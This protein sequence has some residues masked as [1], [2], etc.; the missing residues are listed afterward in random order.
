MA[1]SNKGYVK[2][3]FIDNSG[4]GAPRLSESLNQNFSLKMGQIINIHY[5][6]ENKDAP[7]DVITYDVMLT[8]KTAN[9]IAQ[10]P[11]INCVISNMFGG[12]SDYVEYSLRPN[13]KS[14]IGIGA[15]DNA[16]DLLGSVV[17]V[18]YVDGANETPLIVGGV[19]NKGKGSK[20]SKKDD[21]H[22]LDFV[23]NGVN[24]NINKNGELLIRKDGPTKANGLLDEDNKEGG[25]KEQAG[26]L[27]Q[28]DKDGNINITANK[29]KVNIISDDIN[30]GKSDLKAADRV[31]IAAQVKSELKK[32]IDEHN[33]FANAFATHVHASAAPGPPVPPTVPFIQRA[34]PPAEMASKTTKANS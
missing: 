8:Q 17:V 20:V 34:A 3:H 18:L 26:S 24:V 12:M 13:E 14:M 6:D 19:F 27:I 29:N 16:E 1:P 7:Q 28:I 15:D 5:P 21:G 23:F 11:L 22:F 30:C 32:V 31:A 2:P 33:A 9:N 4:R 10:A 25:T